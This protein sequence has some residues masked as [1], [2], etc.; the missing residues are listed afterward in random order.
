MNN[1]ANE[2]GAMID[3][4]QHGDWE[5][6]R[7][8]TL[9]GQKFDF[10]TDA[11]AAGM[12]TEGILE[13]DYVS[14]DVAHRLLNLPPMEDDVFDL[15]ELEL[16]DVKRA[17]INRTARMAYA[18][19]RARGGLPGPSYHSAKLSGTGSPKT[20]DIP[21]DGSATPAPVEEE[22]E[23]PADTVAAPA[24][25][26]ELEADGGDAEQ[27]GHDEAKELAAVRI[28]AAF[29]GRVVRRLN[30]AKHRAVPI[31]SERIACHTQLAKASQ[32]AR[33]VIGDG[34]GVSKVEQTIADVIASSR[35]KKIFRRRR[36]P[37]WIATQHQ[38]LIVDSESARMHIVAK[39]QLLML[40][41]ATITCY[42]S[43]KQL[44]RVLAA[45]SEE[46]HVE[47]IVTL[48]SR[49]TDIEN[50]DGARLLKHDTFDKDGNGCVMWEELEMLKSEDSPDMYTRCGPFIQHCIV[51][52]ALIAQFRR[53]MR[54]G[55]LCAGCMY[56]AS[57][58]LVLR[59]AVSS[60]CL[61]V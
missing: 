50:F 47:V 54:F 48:F 15:L 2:G 18:Q 42:F 60:Y 61:C 56:T 28:Q 24:A 16:Y 37:W 39:R 7:N 3:T 34:G 9:D 5:N 17:V 11:A 31:L 20:Q 19:E 29:R 22:T 58:G 43:C 30:A 14:T 33:T 25:D 53:H 40:R 36:H 52:T 57:A 51:A 23:P 59:V 27:A 55:L 41:R 10:D 4:S 6:F 49:L 21:P 32:R 12:V 45:V 44:E 38:Q 46:Y 26:P 8:E 35:G 1:V 13:F